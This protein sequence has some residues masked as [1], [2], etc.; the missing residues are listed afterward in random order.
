M[1]TTYKVG[2]EVKCI[3][4]DK[5]P[6]AE[7]APPLSLGEKYPVQDITLDSEGNQH[8]DVGLK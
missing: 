5:L 8:L 7:V 1:K 3:N 6:G 2:H 4:V